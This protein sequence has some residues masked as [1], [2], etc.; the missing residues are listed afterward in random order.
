MVAKEWVG[1]R[2]KKKE[3]HA[4]SYLCVVTASDGNEE[5]WVCSGPLAE[6]RVFST[7]SYSMLASIQLE[8]GKPVTHMAQTS[9][10]VWCT[11]ADTL[12]LVFTEHRSV[13]AQFDAH[14]GEVCTGIASTGKLSGGT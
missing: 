7:K 3:T 14:P 4:I 11:G 5:M 12:A 1:F 13:G 2:G 9:Q 10:A 6:I 8:V